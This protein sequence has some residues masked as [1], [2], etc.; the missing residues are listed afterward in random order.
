MSQCV[1][2]LSH[3]DSFLKAPSCLKS[4]SPVDPLDL[5]PLLTL[6]T[7]L[8][9]FEGHCSTKLGSSHALV[10]PCPIHTSLAS[11]SG[12]TAGKGFLLSRGALLSFSLLAGAAR[13]S[14]IAWDKALVSVSLGVF[15][16]N[17]LIWT[18][19]VNHPSLKIRMTAVQI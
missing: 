1:Q 5:P 9:N 13:I 10:Q 4:Y 3:V 19:E 14:L 17:T 16:R 2:W 15:Y 11:H 8:G 12:P 7:K 18:K 6:N